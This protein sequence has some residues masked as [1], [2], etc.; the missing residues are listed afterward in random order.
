MSRYGVGISWSVANSAQ[1]VE[2]LRYDD[3]GAGNPS[4][5]TETTIAILVPGS[6]GYIDFL[7]ND[8]TLYHYRVRHT[9]ANWTPGGYSAYLRSKAAT[10][11]GFAGPEVVQL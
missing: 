10:I 6:T 1:Q 7:P 9:N 3:D 4:T 11:P 2:V 8:N 5:G